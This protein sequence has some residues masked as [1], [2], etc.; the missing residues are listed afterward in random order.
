MDPAEG[1]YVEVPGYQGL[2]STT[3]IIT[4]KVMTSH[5]PEILPEYNSTL[6]EWFQEKVNAQLTMGQVRP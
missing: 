3:P 2:S 1:L 6:M 5:Y 4:K